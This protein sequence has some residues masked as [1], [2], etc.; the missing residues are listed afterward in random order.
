MV[1]LVT[2]SKFKEFD[3]KLSENLIMNTFS[4]FYLITFLTYKYLL[5][6][7]CRFLKSQTEYFPPA[8]IE[9]KLDAIFKSVIGST[10]KDTLIKDLDQKFSLFKICSDQIGHSIPNSQLHLIVSLKDVV[11]FYKTTIDKRTPLDK[12]KSME[13][14]EN[15]HV[16]FEYHRFHPGKV[17]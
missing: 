12:M 16:Q 10:N 6:H 17:L 1:S 3:L 2:L 13:L 8:D 9:D 7:Y 4:V 11:K 5:E 14:P 15:L